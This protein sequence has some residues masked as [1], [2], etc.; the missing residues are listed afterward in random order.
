M[1][2]GENPARSAYARFLV[3][4]ARTGLIGEDQ[5]RLEPFRSI[6]GARGFRVSDLNEQIAKQNIA[7]VN[8]GPVP[9]WCVISFCLGYCSLG[10]TPT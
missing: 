9:G 10:K 6:E 8:R 5:Q 1:R 2:F 3:F 4:S 7:R